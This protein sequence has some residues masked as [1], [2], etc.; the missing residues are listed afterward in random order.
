M[1][2]VHVEACL[3]RISLKNKEIGK[4]SIKHHRRYFV[5]DIWRYTIKKTKAN[6]PPLFPKAMFLL[7]LLFQFHGSAVS[8]WSKWL[9]CQNVYL[10]STLQFLFH[11]LH[12]SWCKTASLVEWRLTRQDILLTSSLQTIVS[13]VA[14]VIGNPRFPPKQDGSFSHFSLIRIHTLPYQFILFTFPHSR[15]W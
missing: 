15:L 5:V 2:T 1:F 6:F 13:L 14:G 7:E 10:F 4:R 9:Y 12:S 3:C 8:T 11:P